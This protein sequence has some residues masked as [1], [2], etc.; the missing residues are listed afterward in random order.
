MKIKYILENEQPNKTELQDALSTIGIKITPLPIYDN[1]VEV[2]AKWDELFSSDLDPA[3]LYSEK[4]QKI[5]YLFDDEKPNK[6][7][8]IQFSI[9][10]RRP[11]V[12][13]CYAIKTPRGWYQ[14]IRFFYNFKEIKLEIRIPYNTDAT[15]QELED[16]LDYLFDESDFIEKFNVVLKK[17]EEIIQ[18]MNSD[19]K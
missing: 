16:Y 4:L 18:N 6:S 15:K 3:K 13:G 10:T 14:T 19:N 11:E 1:R 8:T 2:I 17:Y 5:D 9:H 12:F 7:I